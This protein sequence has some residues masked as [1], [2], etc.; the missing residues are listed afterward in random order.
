MRKQ[1]IKELGVIDIDRVTS[2]NGRITTFIPIKVIGNEL[3]ELLDTL[4]ADFEEKHPEVENLTFTVNITYIYG[5]MDSPRFELEVIVWDES[6]DKVAEF[7]DEI[8][9]NLSEQA[10]KEVKK[11]IWDALGKSVFNL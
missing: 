11:I 1:N 10:T 7:Y 8:G 5:E 3:D 9:I 6:N 4:Q 2:N